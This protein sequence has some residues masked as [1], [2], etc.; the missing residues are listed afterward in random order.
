MTKIVTV[1]GLPYEV[2]WTGKGWEFSRWQMDLDRIAEKVSGPPP[3]NVFRGDLEETFQIE[4]A[5]PA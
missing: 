5:K 4:M 3:A 1:D 2:V